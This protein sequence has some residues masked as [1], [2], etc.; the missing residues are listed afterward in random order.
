MVLKKR[1]TLFDDWE[2]HS[3]KALYARMLKKDL[4]YLRGYFLKLIPIVLSK[5]FNHP[6]PYI[7]IATAISDRWHQA[8]GIIDCKCFI[9][10]HMTHTN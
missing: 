9:D 10:R 5:H 4:A 3:R 7:E 6:H 8:V 1:S 2:A